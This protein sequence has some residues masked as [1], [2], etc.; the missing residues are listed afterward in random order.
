M[1][2]FILLFLHFYSFGQSEVTILKYQGN[3]IEELIPP[4]WKLLAAA[5]GDLN[6]DT[7]VDIA[8][9]IEKTDKDN[10][11]LNKGGF[12]RDS[13][14]L[15][16]RILGIYFKNKEGE[17]VK[18]LQ[19]DQFIILQDTPT[20]DEPFKGIEILENGMLKIN[21]HFWFSAG[22]WSMSDH[23]YEFKFQNNK[24]E[25]ISY[26]ASERNRGTG[27]TAAYRID[28]LKQKMSIQKTSIDEQNNEINE[29]EISKTFSLK[30][31]PSIQSLGKPF[32]WEFNGVYL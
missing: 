16:P 4:N 14:N 15:N 24:F 20:M 23:S 25:L 12:G 28:F 11:H 32:E 7:I 17:F 2:V 9:V 19:A 22:S 6:Y 26:N 29:K 3:T 31:L 5:K 30:E 13:I 21:F 10:I 18:K 1:K 27:E 8:F